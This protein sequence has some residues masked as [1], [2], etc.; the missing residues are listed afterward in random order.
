MIIFPNRFV[1]KKLICNDLDS[2]PGCF[3]TGPAMH[4]GLNASLLHEAGMFDPLVIQKIDAG[5]L[6]DFYV[7]SNLGII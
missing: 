3:G 1:W 6:T 2:R 5:G 4:R 7:S